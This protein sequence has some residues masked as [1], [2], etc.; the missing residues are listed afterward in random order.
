MAAVQE[1][2]LHYR[3]IVDILGREQEVFLETEKHI[4]RASLED[5]CKERG[6]G[7]TCADLSVRNRKTFGEV[8]SA[9][10]QDNGGVKDPKFTDELPTLD[11]AIETAMAAKQDPNTYVVYPQSD[12]V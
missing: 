2:N 8:F 9:H 4:I 10:L 6:A 11:A 7:A 12:S 5:P 1:T 3:Q